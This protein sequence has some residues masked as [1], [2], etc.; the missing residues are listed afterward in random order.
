[1]FVCTKFIY[2]TTVAGQTTVPIFV[3]TKFVH[4]TAVVGKPTGLSK[5]ACLYAGTG[6]LKLTCQ[7]DGG[8]RSTED[9]F[10]TS[11]AGST[12]SLQECRIT[13]GKLTVLC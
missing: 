1:M 3:C 11:K 6:W 4:F 12:V 7:S 8:T 9:A 2:I 5:E 10:T 13:P